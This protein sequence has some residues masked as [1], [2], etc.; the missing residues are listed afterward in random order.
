L[1][2]NPEPESDRYYRYK[3]VLKDKPDGALINVNADN[4]VW[5]WV[6]GIAIKPGPNSS[7]LTDSDLHDIST[8]LKKGENIIA[9]KTSNHPGYGSMIFQGT[10]QLADGSKFDIL[11]GP[12]WKESKMDK[13]GWQKLQFDD[14]DWGQAVLADAHMQGRDLHNMREPLMASFTKSIAWWRMNIPPGTD[15]V[16]LNGLSQSAKIWIDGQPANLYMQKLNVPDGSKNLVVKIYG[17]ESGLT[18]PA[19]FHC[20]APGSTQTGSWLK[21]G[22]RNFTG[23]ADYEMEIDLPEANSNISLDLGKVL[24]MAEI[25]INGKKVGERLWP[26]FKFNLSNLV[27]PG[28]NKIRVRVG[29]LMVNS[30]G[31]KDDLGTLRHWGWDGVPA[32]TCFDAGLFGPVKIIIGN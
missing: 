31:I 25:W 28:K 20:Q 26:P 8:I 29:N 27:Q 24:H 13:P 1:L 22:L 9:V 21:M 18:R 14:G 10:V 17:N 19:A 3:F 12:D 23:F 30:M 15:E 7:N 2:H 5:F 4:E 16:N 6:N 32:D 11:S